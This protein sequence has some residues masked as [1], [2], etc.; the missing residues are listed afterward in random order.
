MAH[1][2]SSSPAS[3]PQAEAGK[4]AGEGLILRA[5]FWIWEIAELRRLEQRAPAPPARQR[6]QPRAVDILT[7]RQSEP[8]TAAASEGWHSA[9][10]KKT[11]EKRGEA[12]AS[13]RSRQSIIV[14]SVTACEVPAS[15]LH[16]EGGAREGE[17]RWGGLCPGP[18]AAAAGWG[19][20]AGGESLAP[21]S[22]REPPA[23]LLT[24]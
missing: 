1:S 8:F 12:R 23:A 9:A 11:S 15:H 13:L 24:A 22:A 18:R 2:F 16:L 19:A 20:I 6:E 7:P 17:G 14:V 3:Q 5:P 4:A 10:H 21:S